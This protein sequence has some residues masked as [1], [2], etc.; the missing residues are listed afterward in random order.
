MKL[1]TLVVFTGSFLL[2]CVQP[3]MGRTLLPSF[4]GAAAVWTACLVGYQLLLLAG[5]FYA[6]RLAR[7]GLR[8][9]KCFH[10]ALL[11]VAT[12]WSVAFALLQ[13]PVRS[14]LGNG[15]F[16]P[17]AEVMVAV[18]LIVGLPYVMLAAGGTLIQSWIVAGSAEIRARGIYRLY[19]VSNLGSFLGLF[20]HP[21]VLEPYVGVTAQW[22]G[23]SIALA[24]YTLMVA[25]VAKG[26]R[27][28][29]SGEAAPAGENRVAPPTGRWTSSALWFLLP[30]LSTFL[31]VAVTNQLTLD[32]APM[33]LIWAAIL[34]IF[35][36]SYVV[37]FSGIG[38]KLLPLWMVLAAAGLA[39]ATWASIP[40]EG[41][42]PMM[43][44]MGTLRLGLPSYLLLFV[45]LHSWLYSIRPGGA[46]LTKFYLGIASGGAVGGVLAG[47]FAP[48]VF[49][50][51]AEYPVALVSVA[52]A[53]AWFV[54]EYWHPKMSG[55][56]SQVTIAACLL[57]SA[58]IITG[59]KTENER[60]VV[61][62]GRN[63]YGIA[64]VKRYE[65]ANALIHGRTRHGVQI[66][67]SELDRKTPTTYYG[68]I[69]GG[70][71]LEM[72]TKARQDN[73]I[74]FG[75]VGLGIGVLAAYGRPGDSYRF[76][77]I[78]PE[79]VKIAEEKSW[80]TFLRDSRALIEIVVADAR[81][82]L[83]TERAK[84][85]PLY[86]LL[87]V[88]AFSGDSIPIHLITDEAF[89][90]YRSR[91]APNGILA[92]HISNWQFDLFPLCKAQMERM[93]M[94]ATGVIGNG[95]NA[96]A[97]E[98]SYWVFFSEKPIEVPVRGRQ[99]E[100]VDWSGI[101]AGAP[102]SD[103][104]GSL[105]PYLVQFSPLMSHLD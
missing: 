5:Y 12:A 74:R 70:L 33:P 14:I 13:T 51:V 92:V 72:I 64:T 32:V 61:Y 15:G 47:V 93:G 84:G 30:G 81:K 46:A 90:L 9:Q 28:G 41:V 55:G 48:M 1:A 88:D 75:C 18:S 21:L 50:T 79:V 85:S 8:Y 20:F 80:F 58:Q 65:K 69:G 76:Y 26:S 3:M 63:F 37:G 98:V 43:Q 57:V 95:D 35:L 103:Q 96:K 6:H 94:Y 104:Q 34:G 4:G 101:A 77:E 36:L 38:E 105:L 44:L 102:L 66:T 100:I 25:C 62:R 40:R 11:A 29:A 27:E 54:Y 99:I 97:T 22:W 23:F 10:I 2:F 52:L 73:P 67:R 56:L 59:G 53:T 49:R 39:G 91:L 60:D 86:D 19:A 89:D 82:A 7:C 83:E 45:F 17:A 24:A 42:S 31:L 16:P 87:V 78:N 68:E 71:G